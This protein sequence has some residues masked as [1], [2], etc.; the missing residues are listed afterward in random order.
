MSAWNRLNLKNAPQGMTSSSQSDRA[1]LWVSNNKDDG[2]GSLR[3]AI[4]QGHE[5]VKQGKAIEIAFTGNFR[6]KPIQEKCKIYRNM[7]ENNYIPL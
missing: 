1:L 4:D 7:P 5:L 6:I 2:E 3:S